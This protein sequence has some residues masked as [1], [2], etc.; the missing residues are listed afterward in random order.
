MERVAVV[1]GGS[2]GFGLALARRLVNDGWAVVTDAR[3]ADRLVAAVEALDAA[4]R[5]IAIAGDITDPAHRDELAAAARTTRPVRLVV[6]NASTL[7]ASPLPA[8]LELDQ[9]CSARRST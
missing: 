8:L 9:T 5:L 3:H 6:N 4:E 7:G 2:Q 1:T